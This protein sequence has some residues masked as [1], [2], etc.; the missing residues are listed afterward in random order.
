MSKTE[1]IIS[2][3][4]DA[5]RAQ[6]LEWFASYLPHDFCHV[7]HIPPDL[8]PLGGI[9]RGKA[10]SLQ[11]L[12]VIADDFEILR[13]DTSG[14]MIRDDRAGVEIPIRYRHRETGAALETTMANFWAFE[15]GWPVKLTEYHDLG[16]MQAF[17]KT[18]AS[19][20][21]PGAGA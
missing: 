7:I 18:L 1:T 15:D 11:R 6:D 9:S 17:T 10:A 19:L 16:R 8:H 5:W 20:A 14:L 3:I 21:G 2:E 12:A 4:Y 13:F